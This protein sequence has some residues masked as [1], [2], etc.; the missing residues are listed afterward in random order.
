[1]QGGFAP[2][3]DVA[4]ITAGLATG[5]YLRVIHGDD[6]AALQSTDLDQEGLTARQ[7]QVFGR[8]FVDGQQVTRRP[9]RDYQWLAFNAAM[10]EGLQRDLMEE[11][12]NSPRV[13]TRY[14]LVGAAIAIV[15][16]LLVL[17]VGIA[18]L[19]SG[20]GGWGWL[21]VPVV[22]FGLGL[23]LIASVAPT[24]NPPW[25]RLAAQCWDLRTFLRGATPDQLGV[26]DDG[27]LFSKYLPYAISLGCGTRWA[28]HF[29]DLEAQGTTC[30]RPSWFV[31]ETGETASFQAISD[32]FIQWV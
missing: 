15:G 18:L 16:T 13:I 30:P 27:D 9:D 19:P 24:R 26:A 11:S 20:A 6:G 28:R 5:G 7:R 8:L 3:A 4:A 2:E 10:T 22:V 23:V 31:D 14:Q 1:L 29:D 25:P 32:S 17:G 21:V 12:L